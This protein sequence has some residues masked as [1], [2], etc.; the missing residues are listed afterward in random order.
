[1][2][3]LIVDDNREMRLLIRSVLRTITGDVVDCDDGSKA[4]AAYIALR[5][6]W[7]LMDV[8][9]AGLDGLKATSAITAR[10]PEARIVIVTQYTDAVTREAAQAAGAAAFVSKDDLTALRTLLKQ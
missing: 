5:P 2:S 9:M 4:L 6:D 3:I 7:V 8:E 1:M 10:F